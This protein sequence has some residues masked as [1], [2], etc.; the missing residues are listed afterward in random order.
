[1]KMNLNLSL[2]NVASDHQLSLKMNDF[3]SLCFCSAVS[4]NALN[5]KEI[6][7][8]ALVRTRCKPNAKSTLTDEVVMFSLI[9][10]LLPS[11]FNFQRQHY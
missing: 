6:A 8:I 9:K 11:Q 4:V 5:M 1:M 3:W 7:F 10:Y 2:P